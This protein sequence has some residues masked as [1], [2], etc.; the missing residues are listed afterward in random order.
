M[1]AKTKAIAAIATVVLI[2]GVGAGRWMQSSSRKSTKAAQS[3][4]LY[5]LSGTSG[6]AIPDISKIAGGQT[7]IFNLMTKYRLDPRVAMFVS[8]AK[9]EMISQSKT[10]VHYVLTFPNDVTSDEMITITPHQKYTPTAA[11]LHR[12]KNSGV[13]IFG[14]KLSVKQTGSGEALFTLHYYALQSS[15]PAAFQPVIQESSSR[16]KSSGWG[17][18]DFVP[19]VH[20]QEGSDNGS[21]VV[22]GEVMEFVK[23]EAVKGL[24]IAEK[25]KLAKFADNILTMKDLISGYKEM[26]GWLGEIAE[27]KDCAEHP[28]NPL[29]QK[30]SDTAEYQQHVTGSL[31][32]ASWDVQMAAF[33][34]V[35]NITAGALTQF[36]EG[37]FGAG[38]LV[39]PITAMNDEAI[40]AIMEDEIAD[41]RKGVTPCH[42]EQITDGQ[43]RPMQANFTYDCT[44]KSPNEC[45]QFG[46]NCGQAEE[47][48]GLTGTVHMTLDALGFLGGRG[49]GE[50]TIQKNQHASNEYGC[51]SEWHEK[52]KGFGEI[53]LAAGGDSPLNGVVK[54]DFH[55]ETL[56]TDGGSTPCKLP[57]TNWRHENGAIAIGCRFYNV[58][59]VHGGTYSAF[60]NGDSH[61][62][63]TLEIFPQ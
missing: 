17:F 38:L 20:A 60:D 18:F 3:V 21:G 62:T 28:T 14:P 29:T 57:P 25:E 58:N 61:G 12:P 31:D 54:A 7:A 56:R 51:N 40:A 27:M 47:K 44:L 6:S 59:L 43:F 37:A 24:E 39:A 23:T 53:E 22:T 1:N 50:I 49:D 15:L 33:P 4:N 63:C 41:A 35:A 32:D 45:H 34:K 55:S 46:N 52:S 19:S 10:S 16:S 5:T 30:A 42:H 36:M 8:Q 2:L 11:E 26:S 13:Q 9:I 48:R